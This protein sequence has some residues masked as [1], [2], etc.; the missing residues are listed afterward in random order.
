MNA[1]G[2]NAH[3]IFLPIGK[4]DDFTGLIDLA[5]M[6]ARIYDPADASGMSF[7]TVEIPSDYIDQSREYRD[8]L[9]EA[10]ADF[11]DELPIN[12]LR[13]KRSRQMILELLFAKRRFRSIFVE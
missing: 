12:I 2:A 1:L 13:V 3:P 9:I 10:L 6:Q 7:K 4:E 5:A 11:D 8:K